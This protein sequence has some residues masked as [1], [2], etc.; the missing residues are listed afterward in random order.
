MTRDKL[1]W[2]LTQ[3]D[4]L[5]REGFS[6]KTTW[7]WHEG[8]LHPEIEKS[9]KLVK[10]PRPEVLIQYKEMLIVRR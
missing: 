3:I 10:P 8:N 5:E 4:E 1:I 7:T 9:V 6:G 2:V